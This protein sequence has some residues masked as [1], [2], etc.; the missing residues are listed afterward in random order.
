M[1]SRWSPSCAGLGWEDKSVPMWCPPFC[2]PSYGKS[3][4]VRWWHHSL[5][6][7][8]SGYKGCERGVVEYERI[9]GAKVNFDKSEGLQLGAWWASN[10]LPGPFR[11]KW[12]T[13]R[14]LGVWFGPDLQLGRIGRKYKPRWMLRWESGFQGGCLK[15]QGGG[16]C[17][18]RLPSDPLP[19]GCTSSA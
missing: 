12:W 11:V 19:I 3:F 18:V 17:H 8:P 13:V 15:G 2:W 9:A 6:I 1:S 14:I 5:C 16:V 7:P 10:T 4:R